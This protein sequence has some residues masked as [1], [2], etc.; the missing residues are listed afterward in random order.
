MPAD[1]SGHPAHRD[2]SARTGCL[3]PPVQPRD[4]L[5]GLRGAQPSRA[6]LP[7]HTQPKAGLFLGT[8]CRFHRLWEFVCVG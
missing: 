7:P 8:T 2:G 3:L 5:P 1:G 6:G 4:I